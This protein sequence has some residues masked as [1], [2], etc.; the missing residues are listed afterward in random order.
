MIKNTG[1]HTALPRESR[2]RVRCAVKV[3]AG[4]LGIAAT[5]AGCAAVH[6]AP[7]AAGT[8]WLPGQVRQVVHAAEHLR[9]VWSGTGFYPANGVEPLCPGSAAGHV[10]TVGSGPNAFT[11]TCAW[12]GSEFAWGVAK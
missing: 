5:L 10:A 4:L 1:R 7:A 3:A 9:P 6:H 11:V 2:G 8:P 12:D